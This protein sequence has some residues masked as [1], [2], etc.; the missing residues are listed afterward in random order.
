[1]RSEVL[2]LLTQNKNILSFEFVENIKNK[3]E[4]EE[5]VSFLNSAGYDIKN[6]NG[7]Y[8]FEPDESMTEKRIK[9]LLKRDDIKIHIYDELAST[10]DTA[11]EIAENNGTANSK[12]EVV[13]ASR[14]TAGKGRRGRKF[15]SPEGTGLYMSIILR[16]NMSISEAGNITAATAVALSRAVEY[17]TGNKAQIKWVNDIFVNGKKVCGILAESSLNIKEDKLN[18]AVVGIGVNILPPQNGFPTELKDIAGAISNLPVDRNFF[19]ATVINCFDDIYSDIKTKA[20]LHEYK[21]RQFILG[22]NIN[23]IRADSVIPAKAVD[24]DSECRLVVEYENKMT[25][26]LYSGEVSVR[27]V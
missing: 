2:R 7:M 17:V 25:E 12:Y 9:A 3:V 21:D 24:I 11:M 8:R 22:Q 1:M 15:Y 16:P 19:A 18:Y 14:Q 4:F 5:A 27:P 10:N 6:D 20:F 13:I 26:A 23:V